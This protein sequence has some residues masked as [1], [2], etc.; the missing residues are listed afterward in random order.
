MEKKSK[1]ESLLTTGFIIAAMIYLFLSQL[2]D[3]SFVNDKG[4]ILV[5]VFIIFLT[6]VYPI[7]GKTIDRNEYIKLFLKI[8][9]II[10]CILYIFSYNK[11]IAYIIFIMLFLNIINEALFLKSRHVGDYIIFIA[12]I[13]YFILLV[14]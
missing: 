10:S 6:D 5:F 13:I 12:L 8:S 11:I 2:I 9:L 7:L 1:I 14:S 3:C 4:I